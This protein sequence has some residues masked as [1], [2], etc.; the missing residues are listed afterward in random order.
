MSRPVWTPTT[1]AGAV[2]DVDARKVT[3]NHYI[4]LKRTYDLT[5]AAKRKMAEH[6]AALALDGG[7]LVVGVEEDDLGRA[8]EVVP[9]DLAGLAER[10][11]SAAL[12]R[13]DPP[14]EV[15]ITP[16]L[17]PEDEDK[18]TGILL[19]EVPAHPLAPIM[20]D[21]RY[22]GRG[23]RGV[24]RLFDAEV[25]RL[26]QARTLESRHAEQVLD[27]AVKEARADLPQGKIGRLTII[28]EPA[29][30]REVDAMSHVYAENDWWRW[31]QE[32]DDGAAKYVQLH[33]SSDSGLAGCL[34]LG[35]FSPLQMFSGGTRKERQPRGVEVRGAGR[36]TSSEQSGYL[37]LH[38]SG[39]LRLAVNNF[40]TPN[41]E[42]SSVSGSTCRELDWH[43]IVSVTVYVIGM[44][45]QIRQEAGFHSQL[46]V[47]VHV[48]GLTGVVP[49]SIDSAFF[50]RGTATTYRA[51][52]YRRTTRITVQEMDGDPTA[53]MNR[54]WGPLL[55]SMGLGDRFTTSP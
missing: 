25:V 37:Q 27:V 9:V 36:G 53:A 50:H 5:D 35:T 18:A 17:D 2:S 47:G 54:L 32:A 39:A 30:I 46:D 44:F 55:R 3:E 12:Y 13:C 42:Y 26:H 24:R 1:Y 22:F 45:V 29:P 33:G 10:I 20:V 14:V 28:A 19:V 7:V 11:D 16:L 6:V 31:Q 48:D 4:E 23:E 8:V 43:Y 49:R 38:E 21:G 51:D 40:I 52:D 41:R 34:Y 15:T